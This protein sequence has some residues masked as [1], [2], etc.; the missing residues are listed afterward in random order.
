[1]TLY[2]CTLREG[3]QSADI[4]FSLADKL[5]VV[6]LLDDL[7]VA[8][9]ECGN[10]GSNPKDALFYQEVKNHPPKTARL[11][12]F[13]PTC[14]VGANPA[15]DVGLAA[16]LSCDTKSVCIFGKCWDHHVQHVLGATSE[17]NLAIIE[18]TV[19]FLVQAGREVIFDAEHFFDGYLSDSAYAMR[20]LEAALHA[21]ASWLCLCDTR[22]GLF[23]HQITPI[24][25]EAVR[26]FGNRIGF[27]AHN[28]TGMA[29]A[30]SV[31][32]AMA[33]ARM[34]QATLS[35]LGER[36][37]NANLFTLAANL[38]L[39][40]NQPCLPHGAHQRL[41][42]A[43]QAFC[44]I[45]NAPPKPHEPYVGRS[46]FAHKAGMHIDAVVKDPQTFEHIPP[47]SVGNDRRFLLSEVAGRAALLHKLH[48]IAPDLTRSDAKTAEL[49][50]ELKE[51]ERQGY[52]FE[53]AE[54]SFQLHVLR[55]LGRL[56]SYFE[57]RG[58]K[59]MVHEPALDGEIASAIVQLR[60]NGEEEVNAAVGNGPVNALDSAARRALKRFYPVLSAV[61]L[62]DYKVRVLDSTH[63]TGA[64]VRVVIESTNGEQSWSTVGVSTD[65]I[66]ASWQALADSLT[67]AL[68]VCGDGPLARGRS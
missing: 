46:A 8:Y 14:R 55:R 6:A 47:E 9:I 22:G 34:V 13:G 44:E 56:P 7:G 50:A 21:G 39:K 40:L 32:A 49:L 36:C 66:D 42:P 41:T 60:V 27:H 1:M 12:A 53:G 37:G 15:G 35:G 45:I 62:T 16:L 25:G 61:S 29:D 63:A 68:A 65:V 23:P 51:M 10:P 64:S 4:S 58:F 48:G 57:V 17:E 18:N 20:T 30:N 19:R 59:V 31:A 26:A 54:A 52:Q 5:R 24:V 33:G 2:D 11:V 3:A 67:Y 38:Q 28:D 43:A